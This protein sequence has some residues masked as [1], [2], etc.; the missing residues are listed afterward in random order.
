MKAFRVSSIP[1]ALTLA[2]VL[3]WTLSPIYVGVMTSLSTRTSI[4]DVP[5]HWFPSPINLDGY[6]ALLPGAT[7]EG[8]SDQFFAAFVNSVKLAGIATSITLTLSVLSGYA[9]ARLRFRG[10]RVVLLAVVGTIVIPLF[11]LIVPLFRLMSQLHLIGTLPGVIALYVAA[12]TP[13]GIWLFYNYVRDMPVELE[14]AA[15]VDG[16]SRF[17][18][19]RKVVL[20]QM[21]GGIAALT[22]ILLLSTW[23]EFTIPL[24]FASNA[25]DPTAH[26]DHHAVRR[27]V[28]PE[29][30]GDDGRRRPLDAAAGGDRAR[31]RPPHPRDARRLGPL[32][33]GGDD[34]VGVRC[35][36]A[37]QGVGRDRVAGAERQRIPGPAARRARGCWT[38]RRRS[39]YSP[40]A[41]AKAMATGRTGIVGVLVGDASDP[42]FAAIVRGIEDVARQHG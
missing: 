17:Q 33:R 13:L 10:R 41:L 29:H 37:R 15:R 4:S 6:A 39:S 22:A 35:R 12:Y 23:G 25:R 19:F 20:P 30:A 7:G 42:Y 24:I 1:Q 31:P 21:R 27:Q 40:N 26:R 14:E 28:Q 5:P 18:A 32:G 8:T 9:F 34:G 16:C 3:V 11:L 38:R 2:F 36:E